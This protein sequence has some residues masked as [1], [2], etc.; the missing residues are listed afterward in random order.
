MSGILGQ[1]PAVLAA[2][3]RLQAADAVPHPPPQI[4]TTEPAP[5]PN[6]DKIQ[7]LTK[8]PDFSL[9]CKEPRV[10]RPEELHH[11][12]GGAERRRIAR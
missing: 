11:E 6:E 3:R 5:H 8:T 2:H 9:S 12:R 1:S 7:L 10:F 4:P